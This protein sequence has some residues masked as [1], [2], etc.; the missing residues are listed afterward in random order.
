MPR[1]ASN[2]SAVAPWRTSDARPGP[3]RAGVRDAGAGEGDGGGHA[4]LVAGEQPAGVVGE[5]GHEIAVAVELAGQGR[6]DRLRRERVVAAVVQV[7]DRRQR[8]QGVEL[9][10]QREPGEVVVEA[11]EVAFDHGRR[12]DVAEHAAERVDAV[13]DHRQRGA[14]VG[15]DERDV[16]VAGDGAVEHEVGDRPGR[17]EEEL[18]HRP[19]PTE[20]GVL[21]A[22]R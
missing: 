22:R 17:V 14:G 21:P 9:A 5:P 13:D 2:C 1:P 4:G 12:V 8:Q 7:L 20:R 18:E 3:T 11:G 10:G 19:G 16:R 15:D 6:G